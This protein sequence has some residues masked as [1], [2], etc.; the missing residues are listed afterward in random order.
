MSKLPIVS[1]QTMERILRKSGF[2]VVRQKGSH[3]FYRHPGERRL[4]PT[5]P[6]AISRVL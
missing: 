1:G 5:T 2:T 6:D 4:F 3:V